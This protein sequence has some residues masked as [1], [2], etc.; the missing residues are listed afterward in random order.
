MVPR[1]RPEGGGWGFGSRG[2]GQP[3]ADCTRDN[4]VA[5]PVDEIVSGR[6]TPGVFVS[7]DSKE[8]TGEFFVSADSKGFISSLFPT[9]TDC[10]CKCGL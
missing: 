6:G 10:A 2:G 8:V 5:V 1:T 7:A 3:S 4:G 9:L